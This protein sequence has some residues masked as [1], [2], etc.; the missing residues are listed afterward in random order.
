MSER[1]VTPRERMESMKLTRATAPALAASLVL[2]VSACGDDTSAQD[3]AQDSAQPSA[4]AGAEPSAETSVEPAT[5]VEPID[6]GDEPAV[7]KAY[8]KA[9][10][11]A[12]DD[13]LITMVPSVLPAGWTAVGGGYQVEPQWWRMEFSAPTGD[14]TLDQ[15]PGEAGKVLA[16]QQGLAAVDDVD[17]SQWGTGDWSAWDNAGATVMAYDLKG[18]T[19]ILQGADLETVRA[20]AE[21]L[22]P[23][24]DSISQ[25]G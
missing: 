16:D 3:P 18:S 10:L 24:E 8:K 7:R 20:L 13:D 17:L 1:D 5:P 12:V 9:A 22:L 2:L 4:E 15:V 14:V 23:A 25:D 6:L 21:S 11:R 19:V